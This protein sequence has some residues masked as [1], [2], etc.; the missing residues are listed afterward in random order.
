MDDAETYVRWLNDFQVTDGIGGSTRTMSVKAEREWIESAQSASA[1]EHQFAIIRLSD[2]KLLGNCGIFGIHTP[3]MNAEV[4]LFIGEGENRGRGYGAQA[5][6]ML[7]SYGFFYLNL[8]NIMLKA[9]SFNEPAIRM[10][11]KVGFREIGRRRRS[12]Y[13]N[14]KRYDDVFMDILREEFPVNYIRNTHIK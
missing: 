1:Q 10:Y 8:E 2:D 9:F 14:G 7:L 12:Y 13:L 4:G 11:E 3:S 6:R 5:M